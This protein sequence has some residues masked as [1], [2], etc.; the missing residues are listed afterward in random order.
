V[1]FERARP[2]HP[3]AAPP[4]SE[5][6]DDGR[7]KALLDVRVV[8]PAGAA[9]DGASVLLTS[10]ESRESFTTGDDGALVLTLTPGREHQLTVTGEGF[11]PQ[12][13]A[14]QG[15]SGRQTLTM[16]LL[17][18][19]PEGEIKG[20]VRSLR[21]GLPV[22]ARITVG[23]I[24]KTIDTDE[25]GDF[26]IGVPPGQYTLEI[27]APGHETQQRSAT[28]ERLGVTIVVVDLRRA[29]K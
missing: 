1:V 19:L 18:H 7:E 15:V 25:K 26:V 20:N 5:L 2:A 28:V 3:S 14:V 11:E 6:P 23:P 10:A 8:D 22:R 27:V 9:V 17:R 29:P 16:T 12:Q 4:T 13:V 21:G 24:G